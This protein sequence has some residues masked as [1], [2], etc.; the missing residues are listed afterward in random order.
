MGVGQPQRRAALVT[1]PLAALP[2]SPGPVPSGAV[3]DAIHGEE[4][5]RRNA[6]VGVK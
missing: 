6:L 1:P 5:T 4:G 2:P 3:S